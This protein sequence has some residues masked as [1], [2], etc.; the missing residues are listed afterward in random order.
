M[1]RPRYKIILS[2]L[3]L[4]FGPYNAD[5]SRNLLEEF[6]FDRQF[7]ELLQHYSNGD[8]AKA[9]VELILN[10]DIL[11]HL[12]TTPEDP[13]CDALTEPV[14]LER[15]QAILKGH[16]IFFDALAEFA[17]QPH[18][19]VVYLMGNH[20]LGVAWPKVQQLLKER[21]HSELKFELEAYETEGIHI[22]HGNRFVADNR[23]DIDNLFLTRGQKEPVLKMPWGSFFA[24]HFINPLKKERPTIGKVFPFKMYLMWSLL[25]DTR[26][27]LKTILRLVVY[28]LK[29]NFIRDPKR[30]FSF[31]DTWKILGEFSFPLFLD[32]QAQRILKER[33]DIRFVS[34]GHTHHPCYRQFGNPPRGKA[35]EYINTGSWNELIGLELGSLGRQLRLTFAEIHLGAA[36]SP[37]QGEFYAKLKE[38]KGSYRPVEEMV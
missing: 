34:F 37:T 6:H 13:N 18:R 10:G 30:S 2:D 21:I 38:W 36:G 20:D 15:T 32:R 24:I 14:A 3:H 19:S 9:E 27:A 22:E 31:W 33:N 5:G 25:H 1:A 7:V 17:K 23:I 35:K 29:I 8:Y 26:F 11:N 28:F 12:H 4:G 16:P